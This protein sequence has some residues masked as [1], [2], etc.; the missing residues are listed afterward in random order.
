VVPGLFVLLEI[1]I[2]FGAFQIEANRSAA[3][4]GLC[5]IAAAVVCYRLFFR[6]GATA[7]PGPAR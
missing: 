6:S 2:I 7:R 5:W 4:I 1:A 3:W